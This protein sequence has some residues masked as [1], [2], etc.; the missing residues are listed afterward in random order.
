VEYTDNS[1]EDLEGLEMTFARIS[2]LKH[3]FICI[4]ARLTVIL[5]PRMKGLIYNTTY[6]MAV[7][8]AR[9]FV[10]WVQETMLPAIEKDGLLSQPRLMRILNHHDEETECFSLQFAVPDS[11]TLHK[12]YVQQGQQLGEE[13]KRTF[14]G[15]IVGFSTLMEEI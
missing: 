9:N 3:G 11:A 5:S 14:E 6:T 2:K 12:W 1:K 8:E 7:A 10:I 13:L 15:R 4:I